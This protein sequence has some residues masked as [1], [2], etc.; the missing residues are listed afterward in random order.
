MSELENP[1][2][3]TSSEPQSNSSGQA[4][5][6][7]ENQDA[8][9][10]EPG[11]IIDPMLLE[12]M[13]KAG[14][15]YGRKKSKTHPRMKDYIFANRNGMEII[16]LPKT[17]D[18]LEKAGEFLKEISK[19]D[20]LV[21]IVGT[22]PATQEVAESFA[23]KFSFP[24]IAKRWLGGMLTNF[25]TLAKR[26]QH[27]TNLKADRATGKLEKYTKKEQVMFA[28]E[29]QRMDQFFIGL[30]RLSRLPDAL[31]VI[32]ANE[33]MTAVREARRLKIPIVAI[34]GTD[35]DPELVNYPIPA[36]DNSKTSIAWILNRLES[37]IEEGI[38]EKPVK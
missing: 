20:S 18:A 5:P 28:K 17:S 14:I 37:K 21:L 24:Y 7:E 34:I 19:K 36:N 11:R 12:E 3:R 22:K 9:N 6:S 29:I 35:T 8:I 4:A 27:Y 13:V 10:G 16:D 2:T 32:N 23:K 26:I 15:L 30:E 31:L 33:H 38:K 25:K 1:S